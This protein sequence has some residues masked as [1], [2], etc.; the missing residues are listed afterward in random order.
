MYK[1]LALCKAGFL[2]VD[3]KAN[4]CLHLSGMFIIKSKSISVAILLALSFGWGCSKNEEIVEKNVFVKGPDS[5]TPTIVQKP[6]LVLTIQ[7]VA[8]NQPLEFDKRYTNERGEQF[9]VDVLKYY[10]SNIELIYD[11]AT[12]YLPETYFLIDQG[13]DASRTITFPSIPKGKLKG[14]QMLIGVDAPRNCSGAQTGA[15]DPVLGMFWTW[16]SGYIMA[17]M[18]GSY[19]KGNN[20]NAQYIWHCGG[21]AAPFS[22]L[23]TI[24][25]SFNPTTI[26][27]IEQT[28]VH[29]T[30][31]V[32]EWFKTP[33]QLK[34]DSIPVFN[35]PSEIG[36]KVADN[37]ADMFAVK[38]VMK[39]PF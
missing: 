29:I 5:T 36:K 37:Y 28:T 9:T 23:R 27:T 19:T 24:Q 4:V 38:G 15:L 13:R 16:N 33:H 11:T 30:A 2:G 17:K 26:D 20:P 35:D 22:S 32:L 6:Q 39:K 25:L 12:V 14:V 1:R 31:D 7:H 18:E 3:K 8:G 10:L 34:I 21:Y